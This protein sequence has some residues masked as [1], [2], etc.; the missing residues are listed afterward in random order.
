MRRFIN[1]IAALLA[2]AA[3]LV[4]ISYV[5]G[6]MGDAFSGDGG[7]VS[8]VILYWYRYRSAAANLV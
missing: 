3:L 1:I 6:L 5:F 7:I 8:A 4:T 2:L